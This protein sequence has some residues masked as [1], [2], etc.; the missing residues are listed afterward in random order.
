[1]CSI[2]TADHSESHGTLQGYDKV[3]DRINTRNEKPLEILD[4][5]RYNASAS[6]DPIIA[7]VSYILRN[8]ADM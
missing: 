5:V 4:R 8:C 1:V 7:Q 2:A 3:F 6:D